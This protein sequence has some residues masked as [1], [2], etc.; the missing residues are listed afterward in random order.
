MVL[1]ILIKYIFALFAKLT[2]SKLA[3]TVLNVI[4]VPRVSTIIASSSIIA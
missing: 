1:Q 4:D 3:N 2:L